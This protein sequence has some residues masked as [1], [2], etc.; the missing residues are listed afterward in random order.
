MKNKNCSLA[1]FGVRLGAHKSAVFFLYI[2]LL[3]GTS[4]CSLS[5]KGP[6]QTPEKGENLTIM[7]WNVHNFFDG[8]EAGT[9]YPEYQESAGWSA[10]KY[11]GRLNAAASAI[12]KIEP[13]P[14]IIA[15]Q[16]I[17]NLQAISGIAGLLSG[18]AWSHFANN[19]GAALGLGI[20]S[21]HPITA[22]TVHSITID[23]VTT[24]RPVLE[25]QIEAGGESLALFVCHWKSKVGGQEA[26]EETRKASARVI[27]RRIRE[28][29]DEE[30]ALPVIILGDLNE[31][32]D[33]FYRLNGTAVCALLPDDPLSAE[34]AGFLYAGGGTAR[35]HSKM[36]TDFVVI[37]GNKPPA[38]VH[39]PREVLAFY[40]PWTDYTKS[41]SYYYR[42]NWETI[43]HFLL[44]GEFFNGS[45]WDFGDFKVI[46]FPPFT[47]SRGQPASYNP[48]TGTGL[49]D[50]LPLVLTLRMQ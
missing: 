24:P 20:I 33:E 26:T 1:C 37:S 18:Y 44:Y 30:P 11:Q 47:N 15:F 12:K 46:D 25:T 40:S 48:R 4:A 39:F 19:P 14:D 28:L 43:D 49:S 36:Q 7:T 29:A 6:V 35:S 38:A 22:A 2:T 32:H 27:L 9:E 8:I 45:G 17:E 23:G 21:R 50:H 34:L 10:E 41:G 13:K 42:D 5:A 31:N 16:E 3:L